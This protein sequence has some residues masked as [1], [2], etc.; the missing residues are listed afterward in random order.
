MT[1]HLASACLATVVAATSVVTAAQADPRRGH[2]E[3]GG[4]H[5]ARYDRGHHDHRHGYWRGG[6]WIALGVLGATALSALDD[7][8]CYRT[9]RGYIVCED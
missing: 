3:Y 4:D 6:K 8:D 5:H 1:K 9:R 2:R 7:D